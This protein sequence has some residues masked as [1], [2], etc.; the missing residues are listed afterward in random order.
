M[1]SLV[2][3]QKYLIQMY[4]ISLSTIVEQ[5]DGQGVLPMINFLSDIL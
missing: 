2:D 3:T 4:N 5:K 1:S